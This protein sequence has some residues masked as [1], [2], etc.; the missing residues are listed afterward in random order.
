MR[1]RDLKTH[2]Y[3][4]CDHPNCESGFREQC[5]RFG[6]SVE[7]GPCEAPEPP[8]NIDNRP[9]EDDDDRGF[10]A[11]SAPGADRGAP[12]ALLLL[13]V[14]GLLARRRR[15]RRSAGSRPS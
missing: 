9:D 14:V 6:G 10:C 15:Q 8:D 12:A 7:E 13:G 11:V 2:L 4:D 5:E 1:S 3:E